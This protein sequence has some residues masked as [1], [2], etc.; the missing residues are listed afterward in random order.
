MIASISIGIGSQQLCLRAD[1]YP[2][3]GFLLG[4]PWGSPV[5][6]KLKRLEHLLNST[7]P[8]M[9]LARDDAI[10]GFSVSNDLVDRFK[11][12]RH[13]IEFNILGGQYD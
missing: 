10:P 11:N 5:F 9:A 2:E 13:K 8:R 3:Y 7:P 1:Q 12:R 6:I 4:N